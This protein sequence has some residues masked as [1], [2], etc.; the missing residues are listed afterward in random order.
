V[1]GSES[2]SAQRAAASARGDTRPPVLG[3][4]GAACVLS[5]AEENTGIIVKSA[6]CGQGIEPTIRA[7]L[8]EAQTAPAELSLILSSACGEP[9]SD[10][11]ESDGLRAILGAAQPDIFSPLA[12]CG[13]LEGADAVFLV[14]VATLCLRHNLRGSRGN[15]L[16]LATDPSGAC[17]ACE[18]GV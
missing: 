1:T 15:T 6:R 5:R 4:A 2:L 14:A 3:E 16:V 10:R 8:D 18:L 9:E 11:L 13:E 12:L 17:F 7:A